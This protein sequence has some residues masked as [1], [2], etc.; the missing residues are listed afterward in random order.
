MARLADDVKHLPDAPGVYQFKDASGEVIYVGKAGSLKKRVSSYFTG[1]AENNPRLAQLR[2]RAA[3]LEIIVTGNEV[4]ALLLES[5]LIKRFHP[6]FNVL[7]RDDKSYPYLAVTLEEKWPRVA[8]ERGRRR[9]GVMYYGPF[10]SPQAVRNTVDVLRKAFPFR[11]CRRAEPGKSTGKPCLDYHIRLCPGPCINAISEEEYRETIDEVMGFLE[12]K[13]API[14]RQLERKMAE[15]SERQEYEAAARTRDALR[16]LQIILE[17]QQAYSVKG[18]DL[19]AVGMAADELDCCITIFYVRGGKLLGKRDFIMELTPELT[20]AGTLEDFV[21]SF[22]GDAAYVPSEILVSEEF[23][24]TERGVLAEWLSGKRGRRVSVA[25][26]RRGEKKRMV[27]RASENAEQALQMHRLKRAADLNWVTR[28]VNDLTQQLELPAVPYR[29]ECYD[30]SNLGPTDAA[31]SM[32]VFEGGFPLRRDYRRFRIKDV[33]G[34]DDF[35]MMAEVLRRRF[36]RLPGLPDVPD[37]QKE[38]L[39]PGTKVSSGDASEGEAKASVRE[40]FDKRPDL[41]L[42]DGGKG[43]LSAAVR[44]MREL[45]L[46]ELPLAALAKRLEEVYRPGAR[47]PVVLPR[48]S[49]ALYLLQRVRDEAHRY[50]LEYH[51]MM[52]ERRTRVSELDNIPGVGETRKRKLLSHYGSI[53][54][55]REASLEDLNGLKFMDRPSAVSVYEHFRRGEQ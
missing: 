23:G 15:E 30:I 52:R 39:V 1:S 29:I 55:I 16:A 36:A 43:Q 28:A 38:T 37:L 51:R 5:N 40:S 11:D 17:K 3:R 50:A 42:L 12:G 54:R 35:A 44:V 53:K 33:A 32:V 45:G 24:E 10:V 31:G 48:G 41:V 9:K 2:K 34:Q 49:E 14:V 6:D 21:T 4:E 26:P 13:H 22:Y 7:M 47:E 20:A 46:T 8:L 18:G 25:Y 27:G 19:D